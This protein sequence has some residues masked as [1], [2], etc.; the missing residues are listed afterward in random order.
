LYNAFLSFA[1]SKQFMIYIFFYP[2]L[3]SGARKEPKSRLVKV[4]HAAIFPK[5]ALNSSQNSTS[6]APPSKNLK[7]GVT[8]KQFARANKGQKK[9]KN[10]S[11]NASNSTG[12]S[13]SGSN[14]NGLVVGGNSSSRNA[15]SSSS[16]SFASLTAKLE[17]LKEQLSRHQQN[18]EQQQ[19]KP[20]N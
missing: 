4:D 16:S 13:H 1:L 18:R 19:K 3:S 14:T 2:G 15:T 11:N 10:N 20:L 7:Q 5:D 12:S 8:D 9:R 17:S 6:S